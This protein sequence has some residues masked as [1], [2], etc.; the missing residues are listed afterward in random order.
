M[1]CEKDEENWK[2]SVYVVIG[3]NNKGLVDCTH[4]P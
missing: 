4:V 3:V 2:M 1:L